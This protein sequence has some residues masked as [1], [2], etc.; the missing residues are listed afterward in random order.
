MP[1]LGCHGHGWQSHGRSKT[2]RDARSDL[3]IGGSSGR[4][5]AEPGRPGREQLPRAGTVVLGVG[6]PVA[7]HQQPDLRSTGQAQVAQIGGETERACG[8]G[9]RRVHATEDAVGIITQRHRRRCRGWSG[10]W[11][12]GRNRRT[13]SCRRCPPRDSWLA[14]WLTPTRAILPSATPRRPPPPAELAG[15]GVSRRRL[16]QRRRRRGQRLRPRRYRRRERCHP[17][18]LRGRRVCHRRGRP[19]SRHGHHRGRPGR[20]PGPG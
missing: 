10:T 12:G 16:R 4:G 9:H 20:G 17:G 8:V 7:E 11:R 1:G 18:R 13:R 6:D 14:C 5:G 19:R 2:A 3:A 15:D